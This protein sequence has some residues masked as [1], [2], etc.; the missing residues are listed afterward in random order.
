MSDDH[1]LRLWSSKDWKSWKS[2]DFEDQPAAAAWS[3]DGQWLAV[4][5][6]EQTV[7]LES[8]RKWTLRSRCYFAAVL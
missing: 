6:K 3:G 4:A 2:C 8:A 1:T 5:A 7:H